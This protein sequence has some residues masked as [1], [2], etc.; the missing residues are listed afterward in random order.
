MAKQVLEARIRQK[1]D[2]LANWEDNELVLLGGEQAFILN[3]DGTPVNF[4][5]GDGTK[6]FA[7]LPNWIAYDQ[8]AYSKVTGT[9]LP[10]SDGQ[11]HYTILGAGTYT[12]TS[13]ANVVI[14][15]GSLGIV[16]N[17]GTTWSID[18]IVVL[19]TIPIANEFG[20]SNTTAISQSKATEVNNKADSL[21]INKLDKGQYDGTAEDLSITIQTVY[22]SIPL[23]ID[24]L[25]SENTVSS[26]S[27]FKGKQLNDKIGELSPEL[28][29]DFFT[30]I[31]YHASST[32]GQL[33]SNVN[34]KCT[35]FISLNSSQKLSAT[36]LSSG[37]G[38]NQVNFYNINKGFIS[39]LNFASTVQ[40]INLDSS[41]IPSDTAYVILNSSIGNNTTVSLGYKKTIFERVNDTEDFI[42]NTFEN[43]V[44]LF[45][46]DTVTP[47]Q[48]IA[49]NG[50][51]QSSSSFDVS[52]F[53]PVTAGQTYVKNNRGSVAF[54]TTNNVSSFIT[55]S[56]Q[57]NLAAGVTYTA[58][59]GATYMRNAMSKANAG[60]D[61]YIDGK[62]MVVQGTIVPADYIGYQTIKK[63]YLPPTQIA[64]ASVTSQKI[65]DNAVTTSKIADNAVS[66]DKISFKQMTANL[67]NM[68][69]IYALNG[70]INPNSGVFTLVGDG[71][72]AHTY[73]TE[74]DYIPILP[75][76]QY[77]RN[78]DGHF[79][80]YDANKVFISGVNNP[81]VVN[82]K[83]TFTSPANAAFKRESVR[84]VSGDSAGAMWVQGTSIPANYIPFGYKLTGI[85][86]MTKNDIVQS[87]FNRIYGKKWVRE[88]D[89]I[90]AANPTPG[91]PVA[92]YAQQ[93]IDYFGLTGV[94][95][96]VS[97]SRMSGTGT[98]AMNNDARIA[99]IPLD[100]DILTCMAGTNDVAGS[101]AA[102]VAPLGT[103]DSTD[104]ST[105]YGAWN[106][107]VQKA[108]ARVPNAEII[109][110]T[111]PYKQASPDNV[112][113]DYPNGGLP[114]GLFKED[115]RQAIRLI[116]RK[117]GLLC[118]DIGAESGINQL[119][120]ETMIPDAT[121]PGAT[122]NERISRVIINGFKKIKP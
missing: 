60:T 88:G 59:T 102:A 5:I 11:I 52:D 122:G 23:V 64:D 22:N 90:T 109:L 82:G 30:N 24:S 86:Q 92:G 17:N 45:N 111:F 9:T 113:P 89:S 91:N 118:I 42:S 36:G 20:S 57:S 72:G 99:N 116:A 33:V 110:M 49:T 85:I 107:W 50:A 14:P 104:V 96:G 97:G 87:L 95:I 31:G 39:S 68:G 19:P 28:N 6:T 21:S 47:N 83:Y 25:Y 114:N 76:T 106:V 121:H 10:A 41:N 100:T 73:D 12:Q 108:Y 81:G 74:I 15:A 56:F 112:R 32:T 38:K 55:G 80:Y 84:L 119:N 51:N 75:N 4:R 2:T 103:L 120:W 44:N 93:V 98:T 94:T 43:S 46:K 26:L 66:L 115:Y 37:G 77:S 13:G 7:Q 34:S 48:T 105:F 61:P 54:Y 65:A 70:Y 27:A 67:T 63:E 117:Y 78:R 71:S 29:G 62:A 18:N 8:A 35:S 58:P 53:I 101:T 69:N 40:I 16:S 3:E 79:A 1:T